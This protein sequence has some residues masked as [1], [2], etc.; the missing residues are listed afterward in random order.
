MSLDDLRTTIVEATIIAPTYRGLR[1]KASCCR[2]SRHSW[3]HNHRSDFQEEVQQQ[4]ISK[5]LMLLSEAQGA[6]FE[7]FQLARLTVQNACPTT[8][9]I[10]DDCYLGCLMYANT[11]YEC[12]KQT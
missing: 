8:M 5:P 1:R 9:Q 6:H 7:L 11:Q 2:S 12:D 10:A 4:T 3:R